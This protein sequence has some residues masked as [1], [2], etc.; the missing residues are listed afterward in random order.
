MA[1]KRASCLARSGSET[2][3][4]DDWALGL[5]GR[6]GLELLGALVV[7]LAGCTDSP[8]SDPNRTPT[9]FQDVE[10]LLGRRCV[11][12]HQPGNL[13]PFSLATWADVEPK[14]TLI[15]AAVQSLQMPPF[16]PAQTDG[17]PQIDDPRV[18]T[19]AER[20]LIARWA[21][22]GAPA[23]DAHPQE[24]P[25]KPTGP[26]GPPSDRFPMPE[27]Y[28][29][30]GRDSDD[31]RCFLIDPKLTTLAAVSAVSVEPGNRQIVHHAAVYAIPPSEV[32]AIKKL[33]AADP[34]P[35][36][37]CFSGAG[38]LM[39]YSIGLW[40]PGFDAPL[41][42]PRPTVGFYLP[43]GWQLVLQNHYNYANGITAD[44]STVTLWRGT[45]VTEIPH[46]M[47]LADYTFFLPAGAKSTTSSATGEIISPLAT[48]M[49]GQSAPGF[50]YS[51]WAHMHLL[52][53]TFTMD[54]VRPDGSEQCLLHIPVWD[55]HWQTAYRFK[56]PVYAA[57]GDRVRLRCGWD[58]SAENQPAL[59]GTRLPPRDVTY[60]EKTS[61]E[62]CIGTLALL[63]LGF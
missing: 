25:G 37:T 56:K 2:R 7:L 24:L 57:T 34:G 31:Y 12:C 6:L 33:D 45:L 44:L 19:Q 46:I 47:Y 18:M 20:D 29:S 54:L 3:S 52:G 5:L 9:Y 53:Q 49:L 14:A 15:A 4:G 11:S 30:A 21:T 16:P 63:D 39:A 51:A 13:A 42:P 27:S 35:G 43:P 40:V 48:P 22:A 60:G 41:A 8:Q 61:D 36:Y 50:I 38:V 17:C 28:T 62:M 26:L 59:G 32:D 1:M 58:N 10:P 23:G 55:F